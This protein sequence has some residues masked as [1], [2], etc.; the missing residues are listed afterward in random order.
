MELTEQ[1]RKNDM[2]SGSLWNKIL[3][4]AL[5]L[6]ASS[7]LQQLFNAA[8]VAVAGRFAGDAALAAVGAN[9]PVINLF[10]NF[11][12]GLSIG[13]NVIIATAFGKGDK[14]RIH[15]TVHSSVLFSLL[16]G[17][18]FTVVGILMARRILLLVS[19]PPEIMELATK[20]LRIYYLGMPAIMLYN[21]EA[22][23]LR[24]RGD[25]R[26][27]LIVLI[28]SGVINVGMN[29][30]FVIICRM[31][32]EGV[33]IATVLSNVISAGILFVL[34]LREPGELRLE[35]R[36]LRIDPATLRTMLRI[37]LPAGL[38]GV[39]F[40]VSNVCLQ[41]A[42]NILGAD[43]VA[44]NTVGLNY[45][46][47][48]YFILS[49]FSQAAVTFI[50]QNYGAGHYHRCRLVTRWC[51]L[52]GAISVVASCMLFLRFDREFASIF[53]TDPKIAAIAQQRMHAVLTLQVLNMVGEVLTGCLRGLGNSFAPAMIC[54]AGICG[55]RL[56]WVYSLFPKFGTL[57]M[58]LVAY[59]VSWIITAV[60][61]ALVYLR[62]S[63]K[64]LRQPAP[65]SLE[66]SWV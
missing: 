19:T 55:T 63:R 43:T 54:V 3:L 29:L 11:L 62:V 8:D 31:N 28:V 24:S 37:G 25:T 66:D 34:L 5:P 44:G 18:A 52:L 40:A 48:V 35:P 7:I 12:V 64:K 47:I 41:S 26:R 59:P 30:F 13:A 42:L 23:M 2:L 15:K 51:L 45:E 53:T 27:P 57:Q 49:A 65:Q 21:F 46:Y 10:V 60:V 6:A 36:K 33:A 38:Q 20:Y 9:T 4:F 58:L 14:K 32:V 50:G 61:I 17:A 1:Q 39:V 22:A 56:V 16:C